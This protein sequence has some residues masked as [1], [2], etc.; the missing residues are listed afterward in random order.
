MLAAILEKKW[1]TDKIEV[2]TG[3]LITGKLID[4]KFLNLKD[5]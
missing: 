5:F 3:I 1:K 2:T 4:S